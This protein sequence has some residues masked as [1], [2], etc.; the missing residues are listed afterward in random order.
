MIPDI[1]RYVGVKSGSP[2]MA[3]P[4]TTP[5]TIVDGISKFSKFQLEKLQQDWLVLTILIV[6]GSTR[7]SFSELT[8]A[9]LSISSE[10]IMVLCAFQKYSV[11]SLAC[12]D[13]SSHTKKSGIAPNFCR[14]NFPLLS[15]QKSRR[16]FLLAFKNTHAHT[17]NIY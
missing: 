17:I 12:V 16:V 4:S 7:R 5:K 8:D 2:G 15:F 9:R 10:S 6:S 11:D 14:E 3:T 1:G 13:F